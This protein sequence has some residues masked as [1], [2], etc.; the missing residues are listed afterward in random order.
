M[1]QELLRRFYEYEPQMDAQQVR[2]H[3]G[4]VQMKRW[5]ERGQWIEVYGR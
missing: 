2:E 3:F 1:V 5:T 4:L